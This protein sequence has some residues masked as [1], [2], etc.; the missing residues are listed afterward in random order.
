[1]LNEC[2][3]ALSSLFGFQSCGKD[4]KDDGDD[5]EALSEDASPHQQLGLSGFALMEGT[6]TVEKRSSCCHRT[7]R[8]KTTTQDN[9]HRGD[10]LSKAACGCFVLTL[11]GEVH[12]NVFSPNQYLPT[13]A[14]DFVRS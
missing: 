3:T 13:H 4:S 9:A 2:G 11:K 7:W 14:S 1:M 12:P 5:S 6:E 10:M 8:T